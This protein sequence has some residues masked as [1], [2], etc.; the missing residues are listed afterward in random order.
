MLA[1]TLIVAL[2]L[3]LLV[4]LPSP[5]DPVAYTPPEKPP[6]T[7]AL[8]PNS[9][10]AAADRL[11][12]GVLNG[13]EDVAFDGSG[14][15]YTGTA[16]GRIVRLGPDNDAPEPFASTG[17]RPLGLRFDA[18]GRLLVCDARKGLLR[19]D[20]EGRVTVLAAEA[21]GVQIRFADAVD[22]ARDGRIYFSDASVR[23]ALDD[24]LYDL[25][26]ARPHGRLLRHDP[27]T[28]KTAVLLDGLYFANGVALSA[29]QDFVLVAET[30]RYRI[31]RLW[32]TGPK[33]GT[34][35]VFADNLPGFPD[36]V[37]WN[38]RDTFWVALFTV[39][40]DAADRRLH[41]RPWAKRLIAKLPRFV[42]PKP[43][44]Y[45]LVLGLD[46]DGRIVR[47]LHDPEGRRVPQVTSVREHGGSLYLGTL[48][49]DWLG[50][51]RID[52]AR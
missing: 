44:R 36:G 19:V 51:V 18:H 21:A 3:G 31:T 22:V 14:R 8:A 30:Y 38:G 6:L 11:G 10:L 46:R 24:A 40:N 17:G 2:G 26:E 43:Q 39:R 29:D 45:G 35:D 48:D 9:A 27:A 50:R 16:D 42:W 34:T 7:G 12:E 23:F 37:S 52:A 28:G 47:S 15:L 32:L 5:I 1:V 20:L 13:P 25:L 49:Q 33:A 4:V 41:P